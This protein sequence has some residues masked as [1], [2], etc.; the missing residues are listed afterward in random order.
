MNTVKDLLGGKGK[1]ETLTKDEV[2]PGSTRKEWGGTNC[3]QTDAVEW[4]RQMAVAKEDVVK[5][6]LEAVIRRNEASA[7][8]ALKFVE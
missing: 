7:K 4:L 2:L 8:S 5:Q 3:N 6:A 1:W